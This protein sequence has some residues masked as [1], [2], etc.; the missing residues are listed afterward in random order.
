MLKVITKYILTKL[1]IIDPIKKLKINMIKFP[2]VIF[3]VLIKL[4]FN[5]YFSFISIH[6]FAYL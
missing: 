1:I 6:I 4:L 3:I 5:S 2:N